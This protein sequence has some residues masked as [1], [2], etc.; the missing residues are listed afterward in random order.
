MGLDL[1]KGDLQLIMYYREW[2]FSILIYISLKFAARGPIKSEW[3]LDQIMVW[4]WKVNKP[5]PKP[6]LT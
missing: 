4:G 5:L 3:T 2:K 6:V 1:Q